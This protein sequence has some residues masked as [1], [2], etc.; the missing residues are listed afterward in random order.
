LATDGKWYMS[1]ESYEE[2]EDGE[3]VEGDMTDYGPFPSFEA[4]ERFLEK[5]FAN[6]GGYSTDD[7]GR[8]KPPRNPESPT[9]FHRWAAELT[10]VPKRKIVNM[11]NVVLSRAQTGGMHRDQ[12][13]QPIQRIWKV[14]EQAG[15]PY[16]I[17]KSDYEHDVVDGQ[18]VPV[19]KVWL[20]EVP[21]TNERG[22]PDTVYGRVT[23]AGAGPV[24][25]ILSV[26]DV[27]AYAS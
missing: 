22:R 24:N 16:G 23:A 7:S 10:G 5:N 9:R 21:F 3:Q 19:R 13:W 27:T 15:I 1:L 17:T 25:D 18:R 26:Y 14:L 2:D 11:V 6:P 12:Y 8:Q 20:F 4:A